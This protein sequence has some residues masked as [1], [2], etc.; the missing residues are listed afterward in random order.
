M[1]QP[2]SFGDDEI[3]AIHTIASTIPVAARSDFLE[4]LAAELGRGTLPPYGEARVYRAA[5]AARETV[6]PRRV[7]EAS[8]DGTR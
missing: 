2:L 6:C 7:I 4:A 5:I 8:V 1:R 3:A